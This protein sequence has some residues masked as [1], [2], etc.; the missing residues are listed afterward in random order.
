[1]SPDGWHLVIFEDLDDVALDP[2]L[3][4][5]RAPERAVPKSCEAERRTRRR[6]R[7]SVLRLAPLR[8]PN[9]PVSTPATQPQRHAGPEIGPEARSCAFPRKLAPADVAPVKAVGEIDLVDRP[10]GA[11]AGVSRKLSAT[12]VT[13]RTR[14]PFATSAS[15]LSGCAGMED[16][17]ALDLFGSLDFADEAAACRRSGIAPRCND[18]GDRVPA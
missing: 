1:M 5:L 15:P 8:N 6:R 7:G 16:G 13:A 17:Y 3:E 18:H 10:V 2:S 11:G 12:A 4:A 14:P 9:A